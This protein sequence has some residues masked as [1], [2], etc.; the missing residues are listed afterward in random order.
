MAIIGYY[1]ANSECPLQKTKYKFI[2]RTLE[3]EQAS[4]TSVY[5]IFKGMFEDQAPKDKM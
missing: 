1:R 2:P 4:N 5:A 3:E